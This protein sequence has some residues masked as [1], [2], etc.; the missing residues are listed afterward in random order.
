MH[1]DYFRYDKTLCKG[2]F[3]SKGPPLVWASWWICCSYAH[4]QQVKVMM[5]QIWMSIW[6]HNLITREQIFQQCTHSQVLSSPLLSCTNHMNECVFGYMCGEMVFLHFIE[7]TW[8]LSNAPFES[9]KVEWTWTPKWW[10]FWSAH[11]IIP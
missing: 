4:Q 2:L 3:V 1:K 9:I 7:Y 5:M 10:S 6:H 8:T 11:V